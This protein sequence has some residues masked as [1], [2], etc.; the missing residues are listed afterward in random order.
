MGSISAPAANV[1]AYGA[2]PAAAAA[3]LMSG[4]MNAFGTGANG[5]ASAGSQ[6]FSDPAAG[7]VAGMGLSIGQGMLQSGMAKY[8]P[9]LAALWTSLRYY[10]HV[11]NSFVKSKLMRL[12]FPWRSRNW[13]RVPV[14]EALGHTMS[15]GAP[16]AALD[17]GDAV[18]YAP[19]IHDDNAPDLYL[20]LMAFITYVLLNGL[21]KGT[22]EKFTPEVLSSGMSSCIVMAILEVLLLQAGLYG[23]SGNMASW[24]DLTAYTSY[25]YVGLVVNL[26]VG[27]CF[28]RNVYYLVLLY[29]ASA[30]AFFMFNT[31]TPVVRPELYSGGGRPA[32]SGSGAQKNYLVI[33]AAFMQIVLMWWLGAASDMA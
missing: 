31:L 18:A 15:D 9:A 3:S 13:L 5:G 33:G 2:P 1:P 27:L 32:S 25:K 12:L 6:L 4:V 22:R 8:V 16:R 21:L 29:T 23:V 14:S 24:F 30:M 26:T 28:G 20:P 11:N 19:P 10:F 17:A 7:A